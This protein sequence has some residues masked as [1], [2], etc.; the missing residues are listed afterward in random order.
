MR[1]QRPNIPHWA[2]DGNLVAGVFL[3]LA[4]WIAGFS[5]HRTSLLICTLSG[6]IVVATSIGAIMRFSKWQE[7]IAMLVGI[8]LTLS[9]WAFGYSRLVPALVCQVLAGLAVI[10]LSGLELE[11][12]AEASESK[13]H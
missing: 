11:F 2:D 8:H 12:D 4:P 10:I 13:A 9:P 6:A 1:G 5:T 3:M 7:R